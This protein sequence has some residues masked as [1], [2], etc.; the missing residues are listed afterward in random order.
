[1]FLHW[2]PWPTVVLPNQLDSHTTAPSSEPHHPSTF[3]IVLG[4]FP[5]K[6]TTRPTATTTFET[7]I[8]RTPLSLRVDK[9][10]MSTL[11]QNATSS[12]ILKAAKSVTKVEVRKATDKV[13]PTE[14]NTKA[15]TEKTGSVGTKATLDR[16]EEL[17]SQKSQPKVHS[18][19]AKNS[20]TVTENE[21]NRSKTTS[22]VVEGGRTSPRTAGKSYH[23]KPLNFGVT[24][25]VG[26]YVYTSVTAVSSEFLEFIIND[27]LRRVPP[28]NVRPSPSSPLQPDIPFPSLLGTSL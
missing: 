18:P 1:M 11:G 14:N 28:R 10:N 12:P 13:V 25:C 19:L 3:G 4:D 8:T 7:P 17:E 24:L 9:E 5:S 21:E 27:W 15:A 26:K 23:T 2:E 16:V 6:T 22:V 20:Q